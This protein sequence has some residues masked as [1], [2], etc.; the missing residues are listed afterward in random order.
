MM[1]VAEQVEG[2]PAHVLGK[3]GVE[4][5]RGVRIDNRSYIRGPKIRWGG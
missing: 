4:I 1:R 2:I 3:E 5:K